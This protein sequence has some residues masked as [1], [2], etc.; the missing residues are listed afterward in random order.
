METAIIKFNGGR[1]ALICNTCSTIIKTGVDFTE[2]EIKFVL[3]K[4]KH[5]DAQYCE[6]CKLKKMIEETTTPPVDARDEAFQEFRKLLMEAPLDTEY[7]LR[8]LDA[9]SNYLKLIF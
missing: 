2:E 4:D 5:L 9:F 8:L 1:L 7:K 6:T 3:I